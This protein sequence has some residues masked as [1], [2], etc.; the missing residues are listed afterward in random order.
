MIDCMKALLVTPALSAL[1]VRLLVAVLVVV[2]AVHR[3]V[4]EV[5]V[6]QGLPPPLQQLLAGGA[7]AVAEVVCDPSH[8]A[9]LPCHA[10]PGLVTHR[11]T[12][13]ALVEQ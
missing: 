7:G 13:Q 12:R 4:V 5:P 2:R 3:D 1:D 6:A 10:G 11:V 8:V 9:G